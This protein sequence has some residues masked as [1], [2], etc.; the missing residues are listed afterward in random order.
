MTNAGRASIWGVSPSSV[1]FRACWSGY[2][3]PTGNPDAPQVNADGSLNVVQR[4]TIAGVDPTTGSLPCPPANTTP[5]DDTGSDSPDNQV[6][7]YACFNWAPPMAGFVFIPSHITMRS[8][9]TEVVQQ[10]Q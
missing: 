10:Q 4:C 9:V 7:I 8:V 5:S 1:V 2:R 6:T 3:S